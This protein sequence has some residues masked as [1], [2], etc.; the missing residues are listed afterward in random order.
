MLDALVRRRQTALVVG[1]GGVR[2]VDERPRVEPVDVRGRVLCIVARI[3]EARRVVEDVADDGGRTLVLVAQ[4]REAFV[5]RVD[6]DALGW[7]IRVEF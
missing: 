3:V 7:I 2:A 4:L 6:R 5:A 1:E